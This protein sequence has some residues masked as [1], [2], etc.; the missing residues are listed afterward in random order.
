M[1]PRRNIRLL[2]EYDGTRYHGWQRQADAATIQQTLEEAL[3]RLTEEK[4][5][6]IGSGR[7]DAGVHALGQV[8]NFRLNSTIPLKAFHEGLNSMLPKDIAVLAAT[9]AP[10][11]FHARKS[12]LSKTY[13]YRI[14]N[15]GNR[16]PLHYHYAWWLAQPLDLA[17]LAAAAAF[18]PGE[19]DF[20]AFRA[21]GSDNLNPV[22]QI[23]AASWHDGP[24]NWLSFTITATGF[25]RGM[26]R[27]LVGTMVEA[28][29]GKAP[30]TLLAELLASG[31]RH[32]AG[33]TAPPQGLYLVEVLYEI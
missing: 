31:A 2:L 22:R 27:S 4:V 14:L 19:H 30:A 23:S 18:L 25:L 11:E 26:V 3:E 7:T 13:E 24:G 8:A 32:L 5:A 21:S 28:G 9:E 16:S 10:P 12:A 33:P 20:T 29:R 6:L 15:R 1:D 17:A